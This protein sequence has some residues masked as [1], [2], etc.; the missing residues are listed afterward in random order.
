MGIA[1]Q[2]LIGAAC[3]LSTTGKIPFVS[4]FA[5]FATGRAFEIIRNSVC[6]P[7]LNVKICA[8]HAGITVGE[9][10]AS[11][12]SIED[13]SIMRSIPN[14]TVLVPADG[15]EARKMIFE[16]SNYT[17]PVY[18]RLGRSSVPTIF[19]N[20]YDFKIGKGVILKDGTDATIIACGIMVNEA[21]KASEQLEEEGIDVRVINM[22]T[23]KPIDRELI[24]DS[25][26]KT[27]AIIT[28]EEHSTI[29]G[30]GSAVSEVVT[31]EYPV[32][33]KKIG[34]TDVFGQSGTPSELISAYGLTSDNII[35]KVKEAIEYKS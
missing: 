34:V 2:N 5:V 7:N 14:M 6:Y 32:I 4:T 9:D 13:I 29:G 20:D 35:K 27:G 28:A 8:T 24:I 31:E 3:G 15:V 19:N 26:K 18:V 33:V 21:I 30:L 1:E 11:H 23:I 10:G 12:Q 17:G 25:A 16:I 22:P